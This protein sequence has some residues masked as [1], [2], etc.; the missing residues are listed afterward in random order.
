MFDK[1]VL[2]YK[3]GGLLY[4]PAFQKNIVQKI[5]K[6]RLPCLTSAAFCLEDSIRD[7]SL[8]AAEKSL[9]IILRELEGLE[10][11]PLIFVR[12]RSPRHLEIFHE[13]IGSR[14]KILTGYIFPKFDMSNADSYIKLAKEIN[15]PIMPTLETNRVASLLTRRTEL[16][17]LKQAL[18]EIKSIVLNIR[19]GVNDFCNLYGLRR[20]VNRTIYD[21]GIV[22][23]VLIDIL[24][25]FARDYVVAGSVWNFFGGNFW[26]DGLK[27]ELE[28]DKAN[29]FIG[30]SAIHP[31]QLPII[32]DVMKVSKI[33]FDDANQI[34]NW[35]SNSHGVIKSSDGSRMNEIKCH[36][37]WAHKIKILGE[38]YGV[39]ENYEIPNTNVEGER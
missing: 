4:M 27:K 28:L 10:N 26:A 22:R 37:N 33:D 2:Q 5:A 17:S 21:L 13:T 16:L 11:L 36:L 7:E 34:L 29:G 3:V 23:D 15:L 25:V 6:N 12:I 32:F 18:D 30:K 1:E 38:L 24:N 35:Q 31:A 20:N 9:Q 39:T 19:V 8:D 14:S